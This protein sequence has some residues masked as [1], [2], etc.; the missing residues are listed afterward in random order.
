MRHDTLTTAGDFQSLRP[1]GNVHP[2]SAPRPGPVSTSDTVIVPAQEHSLLSTRRSGAT[3]DERPGFTVD[4]WRKK[5]DTQTWPS[6]MNC[7]EQSPGTGAS[8]SVYS[9]SSLLTW[10]ST[11][12]P[13]KQGGGHSLAAS[14]RRSHVRQPSAARPP[15]KKYSPKLTLTQSA[16]PHLQA[17]PR[18]SATRPAKPAT[19]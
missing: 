12:A 19:S 16:R 18:T 1:A 13:P 6:Q 11:V 3:R 7:H 8:S 4:T 2:Q 10:E 17:C 14:I 9:G 15:G 5:P